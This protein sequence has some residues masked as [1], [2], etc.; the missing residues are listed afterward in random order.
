MKKRILSAAIVA[1]AAVALVSW[2]LSLALESGWLRR[3]LLSR[4]ALSFGR[5]VEVSHFGF[6]ILT[7]PRLEADSVTV[8]EDSR[9]GYEYFLHADRLMASLRWA[10]LFRGRIE[11]DTISL[12]RPSL[13]LVRASD[14]RWNI[15]TWLPPAQDQTPTEAVGLGRTASRR[16]AMEPS[17]PLSFFRIRV[18]GGRINFKRG[19]EKLQFALVNVNG[20]LGLASSGR[21]I[22][23]LEARPMRASV[24]LLQESGLL[25]LRGTVGGTSARLRPAALTLNWEKASLADAVR[26]LRVSDL[27]LRGSFGAELS[28]RLE[29]P[30]PGGAQDASGVSAVWRIDGVLR[31]EGVHRW[32]LAG[33]PDNPALNLRISAGW[34]PAEPRLEMK[35]WILEAPHSRL[36]GVGELNWSHGFDPDVQLL[37]SQISLAD[38]LSWRRA[39]YAPIAAELAVDG[40]ID[41]RARVAGWPL[42]FEQFEMASTGAA[43]R[44]AKSL[45]PIRLGAMQASLQGTSVAL[46]PVSVTSAS[47]SEDVKES[48]A[49][50]RN[51]PPAGTLYFEGLLGPFRPGDGPRD[52]AYR[53]AVSGETVRVQD[54]VAAGAA[55]GWRPLGEWALGGLARLQLVWTGSPR[56]GA[57]LSGKFDVRELRLATG[58]LDQPLVVSAA[59]LEFRPGEQRVKLA[60]AQA[61]GA[62]WTGELQRKGAG[63]AWDFDLSA[64]RLDMEELKRRM[65]QRE[66]PGFL[67]RLLA[68]ADSPKAA[69]DHSFAVPPLKAHGHLRVE[70]LVFS[71]MRIERLDSTAD[72]DGPRLA[73]RRAQA[74]FYGGHVRG[75]FTALFSSEPAYE[76]RGQIDRA[77][78]AALST[79]TPSWRNRF[80]GIASGELALSARGVGRQALMASLAGE[81]F[82]HVRDTLIRGITLTPGAS[83]SAPPEADNQNYF[84]TS[85]VSFRVQRGAVVLDPLLLAEGDEQ[86]ELVGNIDFAK[87]L[88]MRVRALTRD[89]LE[90]PSDARLQTDSWTIAG[91]LDSPQPIRQARVASNSAM[92]L[93]RRR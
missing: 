83:G 43:V 60:G 30:P 93:A 84:K 50:A 46:A 77:N 66:Q 71:P 48:T 81:G 38:L 31:F 40:T 52:W 7:G 34:K 4:L 18:D 88:N 22:L 37:S 15:E 57:V 25:R 3:S 10:A 79:E 21:W 20:Q 70:E 68:F 86:L 44:V 82:L 76:F 6:T 35:R 11:F 33:R 51:I 69:Q 41:M 2:G 14:G 54:L 45:V 19:S 29:D 9:F 64:D 75:E 55:L 80:A 32:N 39:F 27:G 53:L 91:T 42:R 67:R 23:D 47:L 62:N 63:S 87:R 12:A 59:N 8:G 78:L 90:Q 58:T 13:N 17:V 92:R 89:N 56:R 85:T 72:L 28:A 36:D 5:P 26:L 16:A 49:P 1:I 73:V 24:A 65:R 61:L 74:D